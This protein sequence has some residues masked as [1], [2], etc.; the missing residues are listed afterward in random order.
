MEKKEIIKTSF[1]PL[2]LLNY[3]YIENLYSFTQ[4]D[5]QE[6]LNYCKYE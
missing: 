2:N 5:K 3:Y 4:Q 6:S 1:W